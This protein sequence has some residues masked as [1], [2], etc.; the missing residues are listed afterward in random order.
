MSETAPWGPAAQTSPCAR[1]A[2]SVTQ[3]SLPSPVLPPELFAVF[4]FE[5][6]QNVSTKIFSS[7]F[8]LMKSNAFLLF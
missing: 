7:N 4:S 6:I 5:L 2:S 3:P 8:D 1:W